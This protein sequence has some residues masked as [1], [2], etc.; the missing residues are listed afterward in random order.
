MSHD[1]S[2]STAQMKPPPAQAEEAISWGKV[3]GVGIGAIVLFTIAIYVSYRFMHGREVALQ[4]QGPAPVPVQVGQGEIGLVEQV[5]FDVSRSFQ[6]YR[7]DRLQ[8]LQSWG[9]I[10]RK[11]GLLHMPIDRAMDLVVQEQGK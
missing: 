9:W 3:L 6:S 2:H 4:P 8:R 5:P 11:Q 10:D 1:P 7:R